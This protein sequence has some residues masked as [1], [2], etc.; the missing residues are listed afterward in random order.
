MCSPFRSDVRTFHRIMARTI[1]PN[2][3]IAHNVSPRGAPCVCVFRLRVIVS[4]GV[5]LGG[6]LV[7][8]P[9]SGAFF[10]KRMKN[11]RSR[12]RESTASP[13]GIDLVRFTNISPVDNGHSSERAIRPKWP[14]SC[15]P[16]QLLC[17]AGLPLCSAAQQ[18]CSL[19]Q[20]CPH[21]L[22]AARRPC[23]GLA[24]RA[25]GVPCRG[26]RLPT[27]TRSPSSRRSSRLCRMETWRAATTLPRP[28]SEGPREAPRSSSRSCVRTRSMP[29]RPL[30]LPTPSTH[31][32]APPTNQS[33]RRL[34]RY[35]PLVKCTRLGRPKRL[36]APIPRGHSASTG[37]PGPVSPSLLSILLRAPPVEP[38]HCSLPSA[39]SAQPDQGPRE[40]PR[41]PHL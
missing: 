25:C 29:R 38:V 33:F 2:N 35:R 34:R 18:L 23:C 31:L 5:F 39:A 21:R 26:R 40:A 12:R 27:W 13:L 1:I 20:L 11:M 4:V 41:T 6:C 3:N 30:H 24:T 36:S 7:R 14:C 17:S 22:L 16:T 9:P 15:S 28:A 32:Y 8:T 19:G 37:T 10:T